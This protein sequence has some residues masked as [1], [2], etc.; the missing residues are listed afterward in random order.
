MKLLVTLVLIPVFTYWRAYVVVVLWDWFI[1]PAFGVQPPSVA[2][3]GGT[4]FALHLALPWPRQRDE[5]TTWEDL[6]KGAAYGVMVPLVNLGLGW[7]WKWW[8]VL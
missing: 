1:Y 3:I 4:L 5:E 8:F 2:L 6:G 7:A